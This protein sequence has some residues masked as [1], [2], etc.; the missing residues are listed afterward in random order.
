MKKNEIILMAALNGIA[1]SCFAEGSN[2]NHAPVTQEVE[3]CYGINKCKGLTSCAVEKDDIDAVKKSFG[4]KYAKSHVYECA[5][6]VGGP[7]KKGFLGWVYV[8]R[9]SCHK[10]DSGFLI[11]KDNSGKKIVDKG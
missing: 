8:A 3:K 1:L 6:N 10:I 4:K 11:D 7:A 9:G 2:G 5:G